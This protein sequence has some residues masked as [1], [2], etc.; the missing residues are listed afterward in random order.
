MSF[1]AALHYKIYTLTNES[2][3]TDHVASILGGCYY[4]EI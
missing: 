1:N 3:R 4:S 2:N